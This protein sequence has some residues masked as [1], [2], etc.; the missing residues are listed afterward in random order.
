MRTHVIVDGTI[1]DRTAIRRANN[2]AHP[3]CAACLREMFGR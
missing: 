2:G 3:G 1:L